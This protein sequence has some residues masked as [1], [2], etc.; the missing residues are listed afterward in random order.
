VLRTNSLN[1]QTGGQTRTYN[2]KGRF[3]SV[4]AKI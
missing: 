4:R 1:R 3:C 2:N